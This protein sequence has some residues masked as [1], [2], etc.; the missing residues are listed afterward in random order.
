MK[1]TLTK[2]DCLVIF[3]CAVFL[4]TALGA[5]GAASRERARRILCKANLYQ[6]YAAIKGFAD[7]NDGTLMASTPW[8]FDSS[9]KF[10]AVFANEM[11][12]DSYATAQGTGTGPDMAAWAIE[13]PSILFSQE[14][15]WPYLKGFNDEN[16]RRVDVISE[17]ITD[18]TSPGAED[19]R[20]RNAWSC[21]STNL[22]D[23]SLND[24][25]WRIR[26]TKGYFRLQYAY[27]ARS[28]LWASSILTDPE[29]IT[30]N[31]LTSSKLLMAD[32][33]YYWSP[34]DIWIYNHGKF[35]SS[36]PYWQSIDA[37]TGIN[38]LFGDG[39]V[40]WKDAS[41]FD[42][43]ILTNPLSAEPRINC[44]FGAYMYY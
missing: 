12:L 22:G 42:S 21:P 28:E 44:G 40:E 9:G 20:F 7:D 31:I 11:F 6:W 19:L 29:D 2:K 16:R 18:Y 5:T 13:D 17:G 3:C 35:G 30:A 33:I 10:T 24:N 26:D 34:A 8:G 37:M 36:D 32:S 39:S 38:K 4:L 25:I 23:A 1:T 14:A 43:N 41:E 27:F 15:L